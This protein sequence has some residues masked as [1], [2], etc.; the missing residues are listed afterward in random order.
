[1]FTALVPHIKSFCLVA[2]GV[3]LLS[4]ETSAAQ[5]VEYSAVHRNSQRSLPQTLTGGAAALRGHLAVERRGISVAV[6]D[7]DRDG[8]PDLVTG[9]AT[10][11]GGALTMQR[12]SAAATS[13]SPSDWAAIQRGEFVTPF[14][15]TANTIELP[16]RPDFLKAIDLDGNGTMD[17]VVAA[18]GDSSV[19]V[20]LGDGSGGFSAARAIPAGG[21]ITALAT[22]RGPEGTNYIAVGVCSGS[23]SCGLHLLAK[24]GTV[25]SSLPLVGAASLIE[26]ASLNGGSV[27]DIAVATGGKVILVD[28]DSVLGGAPHT[29]TLPVSGAVG[30]AAGN[31]VYD[32]RGFPQLAVLG[33]DATVHVLVR[34]GIDSSAA[35]SEEVVA[36]RRAMRLNPKAQL[37]RVKLTSMAWSEPETLLNVGPGSEGGDAPLMLRARLSGGGYDDLAVLAGG[38]FVTVAHPVTLKDGVGKT[39][40]I[41]TIDSTSNPIVAAVPARISPNARQ[42]LV[43]ADR[44]PQPR[45]T[46]LPT[47]KTFTVTT[48]ADGTHSGTTCTGGAV[49]TIRDAVALANNDAAANGQNKVDTINIPAGTYTFTTAFHPANDSQG[50]INYHFDLDASVDIVGAGPGATILN[51]NGLDKIFSADSG[52]VNG[53]A[54]YDVFISGVT[55]ENG[56]NNNN[57]NSAPNSNFFGGLIDWESYGPGN[58]TFNNVIMTGGTAL[59]SSGG[60]LFTSNSNDANTNATEGLVEID[61][62]TISNSSSP[63]QGGGIF[64]GSGCPG[65]LN[66]VTLSSNQAVTSVNPSD[67]VKDGSGGGIYSFGSQATGL[68]TITNSTITNNTATDSGGGAGISAGLSITGTSFTGNTAGA[69]GGGLYYIGGAAGG[70]I[71][72]STFIGNTVIGSSGQT[73]G[74]VYPIDGGGICNQSYGTTSGSQFG[75]LTMHYSRIHGNAGGHATGLGIGCGS[76]ANQYSTVIATDNWW[77][78]NGAA[79]GTGCDTALA[80]STGTQTLTLTPFTT[81]TLSLTSDTPAAGSSFTATGSLGQDS[82]NTVYT[83]PQDA[84]LSGVPATLSIVQNGGGTTNS[85]ATTLS[86]TAAI[87]TTATASAPGPGTATVTVDGTAVTASFTVTSLPASKLVFGTAPATPITSGGN[88]GMVTVQEENSSNNLVTGTSTTIALTVTGPDSY[89]QTYTV[90]TSTGVAAFGLSGVP[91]LTAGTYTYTAT[92]GSLTPALVT[93]VVNP[94]AAVAFKV[95]GLAGFPAPGIVGSATVTAVDNNNNTVTSFSGTVTLSSSDTQASLPAPYT[96]QASDNGAHVFNITLNTAGTQSVTATDGGVTGTQTGIVV[97]NSIWLMNANGTLDRLTNIGGQSFTAGSPSGTSTH[98]ALAFDNNGDVWAVANA[99]SSVVSFSRTGTPLSVPGNVAAGVNTPVSIAIDGLGQVWVANGNNS[100]SVLNSTGAAVTPGT[101]YLGGAISSPSGIVIDSSGSVWL[102][103]SG[104]NS[105]TK[106]IG[107]AAPVTVPTITGTT[108]NTLGE[109]P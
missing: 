45:I 38:Q 83:T 78:C 28:G 97:A 9:Y 60:A 51:G 76:G 65:L 98:T 99:N 92:S 103:N 27:P 24:D 32:R 20:L 37:D 49:C 109:R 68:T 8:T 88:A 106:I 39:T 87:A 52:V 17:V 50:S 72:S 55:M 33:S 42:G 86:S 47:N 2:S 12:G 44:T 4:L 102:S 25:R 34:A 91:L 59:N 43:F 41:L 77:G 69:F 80:A 54:P 107:G 58:L 61:N 1:M 5:Q 14:V 85:S 81:L 66:T 104:N 96:F 57:P 48:T 63:E 11:D 30:L 79:T 7:F 40:P 75:A 95:T 56:I 13:P 89:S 23:T 46:L 64:L 29:Q 19:Y 101:G 26:I 90:Q 62:S 84:A 3:V 10:A 71:T 82:S 6:A 93:E 108:N 100:V 31:F 22:W 53:F 16:V 18:R 15:A 67:T 94:G 74:G 105:V 70:T 73:Y 21:A 36:K 35:T